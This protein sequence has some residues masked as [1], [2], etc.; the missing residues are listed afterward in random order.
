MSPCAQLAAPSGT[1]AKTSD[2]RDAFY[3]VHWY[4][5]PLLTCMNLLTDLAYVTPES[6]D[7]R[8]IAEMDPLW[9]DDE[10]AFLI[11]PEAAMFANPSPMRAVWGG[12]GAFHRP[13]YL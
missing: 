12:R 10:L 3:P 8:Y 13:R 5:Y 6:F 9:V 2:R 7:I 4:V 11:D 1:N